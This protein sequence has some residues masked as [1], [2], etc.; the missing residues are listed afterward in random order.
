[1]KRSFLIYLASLIIM[2]VILASCSYDNPSDENTTAFQP[3]SSAAEAS[4]TTAQPTKEMTAAPSPTA[5][6][7]VISSEYVIIS[8]LET[9]ID[10]REGPE[11]AAEIMGFLNEGD[12]VDILEYGNVCHKILFEGKQAYVLAAHIK[13]EPI[14]YAY[15]PE[16]IKKSGGRTYI[17]EMIDVR[18]LCP[19]I[20]IQLLWAFPGNVLEKQFY[21]VEVCLIQKSTAEKLAAASEIF[22]QDGYRLV[23]YDAYRPYSV[24]VEFYDIVQDGRF[25]ANP[26]KNP[27]THNRGAAVDISLEYIDTGELVEMYS[28]IDTFNISSLRNLPDIYQYK[29]GSK[30]YNE[31]LSQYP[32]ILEYPRRSSAVKEN[33]DYLTNVMESCGFTTIS[34]EW[35]HFNDSDKNIFMVLDYDLEEDIE[36]IP[37]LEYEAY[38]A[39][40]KSQGPLVG[41]PD[42]VVF[43]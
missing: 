38:L 41:L 27:S 22:K 7:S 2:S 23:L 39:E 16:L 1:M 30:R 34:T 13:D 4:I 26:A 37:A 17:S 10:V 32:D 36:W 5:S 31:I 25:V 33:V 20:K 35:W 21:P 8:G 9:S 43:P 42:Y 28:P 24:S 11:D 12:T 19:D 18:H 15:V 3:A 14:K 29:K 6:L 40:K